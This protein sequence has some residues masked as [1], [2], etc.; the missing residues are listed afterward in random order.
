M[1]P[2]LQQPLTVV[3]ANNLFLVLLSFMWMWKAKG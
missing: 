2:M 3:G 1:V